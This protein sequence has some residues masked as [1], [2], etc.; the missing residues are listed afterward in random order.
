[1]IKFSVT[2]VLDD[3][4]ENGDLSEFW[5]SWSSDVAYKGGERE[6]EREREREV[7][8]GVRLRFILVLLSVGHTTKHEINSF[9]I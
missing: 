4:I 8:M 6:R 9:T 2:N 3:H 7:V 5:T 1:M